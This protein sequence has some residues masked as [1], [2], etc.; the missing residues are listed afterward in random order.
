MTLRD[1]LRVG[2]KELAA[3]DIPEA[4]LNAWYLFAYC[5]AMDR[6]RYFLQCDSEAGEEKTLVYRQLLECRK[7]RMPLEYI[8]HETEFMGLPFYVDEHVPV[9]YTHLTLPTK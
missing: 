3:A 9:S 2:E 1:L 8:T 4:E 6:S 7:T 5:F